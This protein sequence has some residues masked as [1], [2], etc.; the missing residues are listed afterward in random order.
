LVQAKANSFVLPA[1]FF[2]ELAVWMSVS[3]APAA[4]MRYQTILRLVWG[5]TAL[6]RHQNPSASCHLKFRDFDA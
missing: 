2:R 5:V 6:R 1:Y 3:D 4:H